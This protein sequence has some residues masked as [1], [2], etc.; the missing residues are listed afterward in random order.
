VILTRIKKNR[1][2]LGF[3]ELAPQLVINGQD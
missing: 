3:F 2:N 1:G